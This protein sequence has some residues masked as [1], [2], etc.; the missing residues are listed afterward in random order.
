MKTLKHIFGIAFVLAMITNSNAQ[1]WITNGLVAYY[2]LAGNGADMAGTNDM[3]F[4]TLPT[5]LN[6][7][8]SDTIH[9]NAGQFTTNRFGKPTGALKFDGVS[10]FYARSK[11]VVAPDVNNNFSMSIWALAQSFSA[12]GEDGTCLLMPTHGHVNYGAGNAGI[13]LFMNNAQVSLTGHSD[14]YGPTLITAGVNEGKWNHVILTCS[15]KVF[16]LYLNGTAVGTNDQSAAS[17]AFHP[18]SGDPYSQT[19]FWI[20]QGGGVGAFCT[21]NNNTGLLD[22]FG[23]FIG[24]VSTFRIY[25]RPLS[26]SEV[27][28]LHFLESPSSINIKT[29]VY[30]DSN[31]LKVG[32][33]Y[34]VQV[35]SDLINWTNHDVAFTATN[36]NWRTTNYWDTDKS[37]KLFFRL[38]EQQ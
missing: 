38:Q 31:T 19:E 35:S 24:A 28:R 34:E 30:L 15:N 10:A 12:V 29:A 22:S 7:L 32:T 36:S 13:G 11:S 1:S 4:I 16:I 14:N 21:F 17:Y 18:S 33:N 25:N 8:A 3:Y 23:R 5:G 2:P 6:A 26:E 27:A 37:G 20:P 9:T